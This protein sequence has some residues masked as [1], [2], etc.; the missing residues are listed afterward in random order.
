[1][2]KRSQE[3]ESLAHQHMDALYTRAIAAEPDMPRVEEVVQRTFQKAY[4]SFASFKGNDDFKM[5][6]FGLLDEVL[7]TRGIHRHAA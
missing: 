3:F 5:W 6:L 7:I 1:M 4:E 2:I